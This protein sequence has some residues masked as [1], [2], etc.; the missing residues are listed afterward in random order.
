MPDNFRYR[1]GDTNPVEAAVDSAV[2]IE[3]GDLVALVSGKAVPADDFADSGTLAE[4]QEAF[5]D[6]FLG[7]AQQRSRA[8]DTDPIRVATSGTFEFDI[9]SATLGLGALVGPAGTGE[10]NAV[11][12]ANQTVISVATPN[13]AV[14]RVQDAIAS[15]T[16]VKVN[17]E[18][19]IMTGGPRA[20]A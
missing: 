2:V 6:L 5:H 17:V 9:A 11:G 20:M 14:G 16:K 7:V 15:A 1:Y 19:V 3:I 8:G 4:N 18:S 12:V 10:A 13:L